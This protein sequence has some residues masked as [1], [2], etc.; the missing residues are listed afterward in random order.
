MVI[1]PRSEEGLSEAVMLEGREILGGQKRPPGYQTGPKA[2]E[3]GKAGQQPAP[4]LRRRKQVSS[5]GGSEDE[6]EV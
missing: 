5:P 1:Q 4:S 3:G 6:E 2:E